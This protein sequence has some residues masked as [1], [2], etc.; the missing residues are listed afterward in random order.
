MA[1]I[2][3]NYLKKNCSVSI[4]REKKDELN[5]DLI[6]DNLRCEVKTI[7]EVDWGSDID[8]DTGLGKKRTRGPDL[9]YDIGKF[10]EKKDSGYKG[11][12]QSDVLFADLTLK[13]F[14]S[15][16]KDIIGF[17]LGDKLQYGL[18][19]LKKYRIIFFS[20]FYLDCVG[21][22]IDFEPRLWNLI[23]IASGIEYRNATL[24]FSIPA[25][26]KLHKIE[27]PEPPED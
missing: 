8:P 9:C 10:I 17:G 24:S 2:A 15:I 5:P 22:Y 25:D 6:V 14:G 4:H 23:D 20:R 19:E 13:S 3:F 18:P 1:V 27:I 21:Y 7:Q 26:G 12:L 16:S 11:I